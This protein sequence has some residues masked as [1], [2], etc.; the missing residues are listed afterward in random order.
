MDSVL[1]MLTVR[2]RICDSIQI[3]V[4]LKEAN[5]PKRK[6]LLST[7]SVGEGGGGQKMEIMQEEIAEKGD[8]DCE[9]KNSH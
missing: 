1:N 5:Q 3:F 4:F 2:M 7:L 8:P 6:Q 9:Q